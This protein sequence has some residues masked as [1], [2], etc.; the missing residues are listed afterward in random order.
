MHCFWDPSEDAAYPK[1]HYRVAVGK[2]R[3]AEDARE[4]HVPQF[5]YIHEIIGYNGYSDYKNN[6]ANDIALVVLDNYIQFHAYVVPICLPP[7]NPTEDEMD[8]PPGSLGLTAGIVCWRDD[9]HNGNAHSCLMDSRPHRL[10]PEPDERCAERRA[11]E[12]RAAGGEP[13][14]VHREIDARVRE[15]HHGR[16]ILCRL[17][18]RGECLPGRLGRRTGVRAAE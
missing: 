14:R 3:R 13:R 9:W 18:E 7:D 5:F 17:F 4:E 1:S 12:D 2:S 16:Q 6:Y 11:Q 15:L 8:V 10:G